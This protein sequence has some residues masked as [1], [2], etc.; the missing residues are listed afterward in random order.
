MLLLLLQVNF[1]DVD[2]TAEKLSKE[3][4]NFFHHNVA[5]R[6]FLCKQARPDI[7]TAV[8]FLCTRVKSPN[9]DDYK[10]LGRVMNYLQS[11]PSLPL[12]LEADS[13]GILNWW[14]DAAYAVHPDMKGYTGGALSR[15]TGVIYGTSTKQKLVTRSST[16]AELVGIHDVLPQII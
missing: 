9:I 2:Y 14:V 15:G 4:S 3:S 5:K 12:T 6:L 1:F 11:N 7:Q 13:S 16:E 10:K 8:A